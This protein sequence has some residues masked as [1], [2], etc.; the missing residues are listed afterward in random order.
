[1][2]V[3][4]DLLFNEEIKLEAWEVAG[5]YKAANGNFLIENCDGLIYET[6]NYTKT[7]V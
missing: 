7:E 5:I 1:M 4:I 6:K 3:F 2:L